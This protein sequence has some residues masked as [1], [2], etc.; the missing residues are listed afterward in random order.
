MRLI[1]YFIL[2]LV[3]FSACRK[4]QKQASTEGSYT[5][6]LLS[7]DSIEILYSD[8]ALVVIRLQ[9]AKQFEYESGNREFPEGIFVEFFEKDGTISSTLEADKGYFF[10]E[11]DRYTAVGNVVIDSKKED[12][13]LYTDT[14]HWS[15]PTEKVYTKAK[16][17]IVQGPDTLRGQG[18]EAAQ[19]F[20][21]YE[22][23]K[24][25]GNLGLGNDDITPE[26]SSD[27]LA[28]QPPLLD[29]ANDDAFKKASPSTRL[30]NE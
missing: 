26:P 12:N 10:R 24:P 3:L 9:A 8:S 18:L 11:Q 19:D 6:P 7:A 1:L 27:S 14:L 20:S 17:L 25:E 15:P 28:P 2:A 5:G 29:K 23:M 4:K 21:T 16:V 13:Q 22:I 30:P